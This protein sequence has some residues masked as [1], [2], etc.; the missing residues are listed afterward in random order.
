MHL[1]EVILYSFIIMSLFGFALYQAFRE[2]KKGSKSQHHWEK[3]GA[4]ITMNTRADIKRDIAKLVRPLFKKKTP[5]KSSKKGLNKN[6]L[7]DIRGRD[8]DLPSNK[9]LREKY[10]K[11][12]YLKKVKN[13]LRK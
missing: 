13:K 8:I 10:V 2:V 11:D 9:E 12:E 6:G 1:T 3:Y 7:I 4:E 5:S